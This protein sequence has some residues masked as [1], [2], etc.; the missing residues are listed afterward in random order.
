MYVLQEAWFDQ[1]HVKL[2]GFSS[3]GIH[4]VMAWYGGNVKISLLPTSLLAVDMP[5]SLPPTP[6]PP[7][8]LDRSPE[9]ACV[10]LTLPALDPVGAPFQPA[11]ITSTAKT[12]DVFPATLVVP[13]VPIH[14]E[15]VVSLT[16]RV[17]S[18]ARKG[19]EPV[20]STNQVPLWA[21]D[22]SRLLRKKERNC[23]ESQGGR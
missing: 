2:W 8:L 3:G 23:L 4:A 22:N 17:P 15:L 20:C 12:A 13:L 5:L 9:P 7:C 16:Y 18:P 1:K 14:H 19:V 21:R 6:P 11:P 10:V